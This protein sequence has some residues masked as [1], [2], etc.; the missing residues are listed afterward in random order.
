[1]HTIKKTARLYQYSDKGAPRL[2]HKPTGIQTILKACLVTGYGDKEGAGWQVIEGDD[3]SKT[4]VPPFEFESFGF[5]VSNDT[6]TEVT[7]Q[8]VA[9]DS[10]KAQCD[11]PFKYGAGTLRSEKWCVIACE[12]GVWFFAQAPNQNNIPEERAGVYL[13]CGYTS[14][15]ENGLRGVYLKHTGGSWGIGD[16]D[17]YSIV[18]SQNGTSGQTFGKLWVG[19]ALLGEQVFTVNPS[20]VFDSQDLGVNPILAPM[21]IIAGGQVYRIPVFGAS[22]NRVPNRTMLDNH[23][24]HSTSMY[25]SANNVFVP[26]EWEL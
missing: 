12:F 21:L 9:D 15:D 14:T 1:M 4:F 26:L 10:V 11:T 25:Q 3:N 22:T 20:C 8:I 24:C 23:L 6:G 7:A 18:S 13:Y 17:R 16:D 5:K 2:D 19:N